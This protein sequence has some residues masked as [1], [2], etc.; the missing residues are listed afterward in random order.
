MKKEMK[1][2]EEDLVLSAGKSP[3]PHITLDEI[4]SITIGENKEHRIPPLSL[5]TVN[6]TKTDRFDLIPRRSRPTL[7]PNQIRNR[8]HPPQPPQ[9]PSS[10]LRPPLHLPYHPPKHLHRAR[11][12]FH[13]GAGQGG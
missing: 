3:S 10:E 5:N 8:P 12:F 1:G 4:P 9:H 11:T 2:I 6:Q 13:S 7:P